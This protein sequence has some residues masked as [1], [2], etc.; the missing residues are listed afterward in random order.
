MSAKHLTQKCVRHLEWLFRDN[1][2]VPV[3]A[4]RNQAKRR[5]DLGPAQWGPPYS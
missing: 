3:G 1:P 5:S 4:S 2:L